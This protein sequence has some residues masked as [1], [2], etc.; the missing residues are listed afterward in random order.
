[1]KKSQSKYYKLYNG[2]SLDVL[3]TFKSNSVDS[4]VTDPPYGMSKEPNA[5][6]MLNSWLIKDYYEHKSKSGFM[7]KSWDAFVPQPI[8]WKEAL[9]VLKPGGYCLAFF[10]TRTYDLGVLALRLAGFEIRDSLQWLY[11]T[12][13]PK[14]QSIDKLIDKKL[15]KK[16]KI[17]GKR[18]HPTLK[19]SSK[20]DRQVKQQFHGKNSIRDEWDITEPGCE[21]SKK[22]EGFGT[23]LKPAVEII[24]LARKPLE[25]TVA[26]NILKHGTGALNID[27]S[28]IQFSKN[29]DSRIG[30]NYKHNAHLGF[31]TGNNQ[32]ITGESISLHKEQGRFPSNVILTHDRRCKIVKDAFTCHKDCPIK[33]LDSQS[34]ASRFFYCA[35]TS[36]RERN[37]GLDDL[38]SINLK[39]KSANMPGLKSGVNNSSK[40]G[41]RNPNLSTKNDH[42]TVKPVDLMRYLVKL[43]TPPKGIVLDPFMGSGTTGIAAF[44]ERFLF[45]GIDQDLHYC[46]I[47][48]ARIN[49][50]IK[51][52]LKDK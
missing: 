5:I 43:V 7:G 39:D 31:K 17:V 30:K 41:K 27:A 28:R 35:K 49:H 8:F 11:G 15:N 4:V 9:R 6:E 40:S 10:S 32:N 1:M 16:R 44:E 22:W 13:F 3:K 48:K 14:S 52:Y 51:E 12:G 33:M 47:A 21:E 34:Y 36:R 42:P 38:A 2:D 26:D 46:K 37:E 45:I 19:D 29:D 50:R 25:G 24:V 18:K 23:A 20:I